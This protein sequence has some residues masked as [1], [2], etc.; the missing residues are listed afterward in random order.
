M[1]SKSKENDDFPEH[2]DIKH[3]INLSPNYVA[4]VKI[5]SEVRQN[6]TV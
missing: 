6:G 4:S 3:E 5:T 2:I 1:D